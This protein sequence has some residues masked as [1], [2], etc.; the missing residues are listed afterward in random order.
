MNSEEKSNLINHLRFH[1]KNNN[2]GYEYFL[3]KWEQLDEE[4]ANSLKQPLIVMC[5]QEMQ[6][7]EFITASYFEFQKVTIFFEDEFIPQANKFNISNAATKN[8]I[9]KI[10]M[11]LKQLGYITNT[12]EETAKLISIVFDIGYDTAL[13]YLKN[14]GKQ[15][16][17]RNLLD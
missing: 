14:P 5:Y 10:F 16:S 2:E 7:E 15:V 13:S 1:I 8:E 4:D 6:K 11:R 9:V 3:K 12:N 17:V